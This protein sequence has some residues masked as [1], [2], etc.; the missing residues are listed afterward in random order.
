MS[1]SALK[2]AR[3]WPRYVA[4]AIALLF[5]VL[6]GGVFALRAAL[7]SGRFTPRIKA[8]IENATGYRAEIGAVDLALGLIPKLELRDVALSTPGGATPGLVAPRLAATVSLFSLISGGI[9]IPHIEAD[10]L[11]LNL[12]PALW[13]L[14][15]AARPAREASAAPAPSRQAGAMPHIGVVSLRDAH[16]I[17]P[18]NG[19]DIEIPSLT[20]H[21]IGTARASDLAAE[22]R[23]QGITFTLAGQAGPLLGGAPGKLP[24]LGTLTFKAGAGDLGWL[25]PGLRLE[26]L[27]MIAPPEGE[28]KLNGSFTRAGNAIRLEASLGEIGR[29]LQGAQAPLP[30]E[31]RLVAGAASLTLQGRVARPRDLADVQ[32]DLTLDAPDAAGLTGVTALPPGLRGSARLEWR[33]AQNISLPRLQVTS[34]ALVGTAALTL[35]LA[36]RPSLTGRID[37]TRL[38]LDGLSAA[39]VPSTARPAPVAP[40]PTAGDGRVI[41]EIGVPVAALNALD[42]ELALALR[43]VTSSSLPQ[44]AVQ[45]NLRLRN[46]ALTL[47]PF[48]LTIPAGQLSGQVTVNAAANPAQFGLRL[49]SDGAGLELAALSGALDGLGLRG[50][51]EIATDLRGTGATTRA[52]AASLNGDMGLALVNARLEQGAALDALG[53]LLALISP[54]SQR[55]GAVEL[56]CVALAFGAEQGI[57]QS[58]AL[59]MDSAIGQI[60]GQAGINLRDESLNGRLNTNL[61]VL[62]VALRAPVNLGGTLA[63]PRLGVP[64]GAA[65]GQN[66]AGLLADTL[67]GRVVTDPLGNLLGG[68]GRNAEADCAEPLRIARLGADGPAPTPRAAPEAGQEAPRPS[69]PALPSPVQ[70]V[71]RGLGGILGGGRR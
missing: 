60:N 35:A 17:L 50:R 37:V 20:I 56:R 64:P 13:A 3:R 10:G 66:A 41:P 51:G 15:T 1:A 53:A 28:A 36:D 6:L 58:R 62:G 19:R 2:P 70:D 18:G 23:Y 29:L 47:A 61:R 39:P 44:M 49:R 12:D 43:G 65:L 67:T 63:A 32:F 59:F 68:A 38:D 26:A 7:E 16:V 22:W 30:I 40:A 4:G 21:N 31:A 42:A 69:V 55:L 48:N 8:E 71:L 5:V 14:P 45:T 24:P 27:D 11:K 52:I 54:T 57:A 33:D 9:E 46:G 25:L 34:P